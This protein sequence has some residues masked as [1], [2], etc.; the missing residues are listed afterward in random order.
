MFA[1]KSLVSRLRQISRALTLLILLSLATTIW[2]NS[3]RNLL[4]PQSSLLSRIDEPP[5]QEAYE[6]RAFTHNWH[7]NSYVVYPVAE[8]EIA[9]LVVTRND[10]GGFSDIYHTSDSVDV[11]DVCMIWGGNAR[12]AVYRNFD[13]WS[14]PFSCWYRPKRHIG[15]NAKFEE[16]ALSN[17]HVVAKDEKLAKRLNSIR[18]GD[19]VRLKGKLINY[20]PAG[21]SEQLRRSSLTRKDTGN[22]ACEVMYVEEFELLKSGNPGWNRVYDMARSI[23]LISILIKIVSFLIFPYL[24]YRFTE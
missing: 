5:S 7:G 8:Y 3:K 14:E 13:F 2:S 1:Q 18:L 23:L 16:D 22:G 11:V 12:E 24:E 19:Q 10:I 21:A 17:T 9:G 15:G 6:D 20:H 4:P